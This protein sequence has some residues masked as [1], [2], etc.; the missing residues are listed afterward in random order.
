MF[1]N[2]PYVLATMWADVRCI[3]SLGFDLQN[4]RQLLIL[5]VYAYVDIE[6]W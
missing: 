2:V 5:K 1:I 6:K 3:C 4:K